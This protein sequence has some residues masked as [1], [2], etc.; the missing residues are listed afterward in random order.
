MEHEATP[1][2]RY[3]RMHYQSQADMAAHLGVHSQLV[4]YWVCNGWYVINHRL[5]SPRRRLPKPPK[6]AFTQQQSTHE[7]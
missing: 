7:G 3:I 2:A 5:Y 6:E 4:S 1:L